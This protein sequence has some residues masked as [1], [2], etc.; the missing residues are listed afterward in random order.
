MSTVLNPIAEARERIGDRYEVRVLEPAPPAVLHEPFAD[1]PMARGEVPAGRGVVAPFETGVAGDVTWHDLASADPD[2]A[3]WCADRALGAWPAAPAITDPAALERTRL[4][5]HSVAEHVLC[6]AR[7]RVNGKIGLRFTRGGFGTPFF[8]AD[9]QVRVEGSALVHTAGATAQAMP[10]EL[11][12]VRAAA[13]AVGVE[14]GAPDLFRPTTPLD[15][16]RA[17][18]LEPAAVGIFA[19]WF[20][21]AAAVLAQLRADTIASPGPPPSLVQLWPE[22]FDLACDLGDTAAGRR[23]NFGASPGDALHPEPYLYV[24]PWDLAGLPGA[25]DPYWNE[26]FG[27]SLPYSALRGPAGAHETALAFFREGRALLA[28]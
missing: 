21:L 4:A 2:L 8:G 18:E 16:D 24:G 9:E 28:G 1:D 27:A 17:L 20:G 6:P 14:A 11:T 25:T 5:L 12:T 15:L 23:A 3:L 13:A 7:H 26:P 19:W 10:T 22:H